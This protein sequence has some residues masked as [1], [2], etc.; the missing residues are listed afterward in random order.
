M[1]RLTNALIFALMIIAAVVCGTIA[2][3]GNAWAL[4]ICYWAV[5]TVKNGA[6]WIAAQRKSERAGSEIGK[7]DVSS[8]GEQP[9]S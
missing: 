6:D 1:R 2:A 8:N 7:R 4:I 9:R 5:L 3:G